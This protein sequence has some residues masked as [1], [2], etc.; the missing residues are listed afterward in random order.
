MTTP[1]DA[2]PPDLKKSRALDSPAEATRR[3]TPPPVSATRAPMSPIDAAKAAASEPGVDSLKSHMPAGELGV[4]N[5][6][7][8]ILSTA[9]GGTSK[10]EDTTRAAGYVADLTKA[11]E[12]PPGPPVAKEPANFAGPEAETVPPVV[13]T[14]PPGPGPKPP[15]PDPLGS[16]PTPRPTPPPTPPPTPANPVRK[17]D[18]EPENPADPTKNPAQVGQVGARGAMSAWPP[19]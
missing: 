9:S 13:R 1:N 8:L 14:P 18:R 12:P 2:L 15:V 7:G 6:P 17:P 10:A 5:P 3:L 4:R 19:T 11:N 16:D